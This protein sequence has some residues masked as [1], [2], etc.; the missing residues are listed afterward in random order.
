MSGQLGSDQ[1]PSHVQ[2]KEGQSGLKE[3]QL[4][5]GR[6]LTWWSSEEAITKDEGGQR[7]KMSLEGGLLG[8]A[9]PAG[10][11]SRGQGLDFN[12]KL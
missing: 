10:C 12:G 7:G 5:E 3:E 4:Q 8:D 6:T 11:Q 9:V 2:L 1:N